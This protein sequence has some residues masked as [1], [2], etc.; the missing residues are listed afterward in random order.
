MYV[1]YRNDETIKN[2]LTSTMY[3]HYGSHLLQCPS[4][5]NSF[6]SADM[7]PIKTGEF[8]KG[9]ESSSDNVL[10]YECNKLEN[11]V[12]RIEPYVGIDYSRFSLKGV[13]V[14]LHHT[15]HSGTMAVNPY[16]KNPDLKEEQSIEY[17]KDSIM[18]LKK[19]CD[20]RCPK[21]ELYIELCSKE[22]T[23]LYETTG[24]VLRSKVG[25]SWRTT[26]EMAYIKLLIGSS[27]GYEGKELQEFVD[28]EINGEFVR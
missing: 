12:L 4:H 9:K 17:T 23:Y 19:R 8:F 22:N 25:T 6:Y 10:L 27:L 26:S 15:Y 11:C 2:K 28:S 7:K 24:I 5:S 16:H 13:K 21:T 3:I 14:V 20:K 1:A 18:Y